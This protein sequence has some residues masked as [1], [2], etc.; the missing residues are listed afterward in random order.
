MALF[1]NNPW[2]G[3]LQRSYEQVKA[4]LLTRLTTSNPEI[5]DHSESNIL[6]VIIGMFAGVVEHLNYYIDNMAREAYI[7]TARFFSSMVRLVRILD[8]RIKAKIPATVTLTVSLEDGSGNAQPAAAPAFIPAGTVIQ[9]SNGVS[10]RTTDDLTINAGDTVLT[11]GASQYTLIASTSL[12]NTTGVANETFVIGTD[13]VHN[14]IYVVINGQIW[15]EKTTLGL[16]GPLDR[17]FVVDINTSG[18]AYIQFG[19]GTF[20]QIPPSPFSVNASWRDSLGASGNLISEGTISNWASPPTVPG[21]TAVLVTNNLKPSGGSDYEDIERMRFRVPLSIRTLDRAVTPTD[22]NDVALLAPGVLKAKTRF[23]CSETQC[24]E[25]YIGPEGGGIAQVPL[26]N[27][28]EAFVCERKMVTDRVCT[29][30]AGI[31]P[32]PLL[33]IVNAK[34]GVDTVLLQTEVENIIANNFG[35]ANNQI[36]Q[37]IFLSDIYNTVDSLLNVE[38]LDISWITTRPYARAYNHINELNW[39]RIVTSNSTTTHNWKMQ[40]QGANTF[41]VWKDDILQGF[42][43]IGSPFTDTDNIIEFTISLGVYAIGNVWKFKTYQYGGNQM[44]DD[45]SVPV[46]EATVQVV[47]SASN[48]CQQSC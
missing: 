24:I 36:N 12:G 29:K 16:S 23:C 2:V 14:S 4:S 5:T 6:V 26:L 31:T 43:T 21:V 1:D 32:V 47:P 7:D 39:T 17:H 8:Y 37:G 42:A 27:S 45:Y 18:E 9:T 40:Y 22:Y 20:G 3:Y 44:I 35:Y 38:N 33:A 19:D 48:N 11:I 41:G 28:T 34:P 30:A 10:F 15:T 25:I 46:V 13:Y